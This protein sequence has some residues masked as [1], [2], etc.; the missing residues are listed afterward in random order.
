M[1]HKIFLNLNKGITAFVMLAFIA[2]YNQW[3]NPTAW[4]YLALHGTYGFLWI[5]KSCIYP[6]SAWEHKTS[7]WFGVVSWFALTLYWI[8]GWLIMSRNTQAPAWYL[9][10]CI[11]LYVFGIFFHFTSDMQ[12]HVM[13]ELRPKELITNR[14]M[15]LS[16]NSNYFGE[17]LI[18]LSFALLP[19]TWLALIPLIVFI[20]FYWSFMLIKKEKSLAQKPGFLEYKKRTKWFIPFIF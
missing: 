18:Y 4:V 14:M 6:D 7:I 15:A 12:K 13:L 5:L 19:I 3:Q 1:K 11:S 10:L 20:V 17:F 2:A 16:R 8:P 9:G